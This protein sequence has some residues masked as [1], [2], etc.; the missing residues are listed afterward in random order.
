MALRPPRAASPVTWMFTCID[1]P[2]DKVNCAEAG[3]AVA[4]TASPTS[5]TAAHSRRVPIA[6]SPNSRAAERARR[7]NE[8]T[9]CVLCRVAVANVRPVSS[10]TDTLL[11]L[12]RTRRTVHLRAGGWRAIRGLSTHRGQTLVQDVILAIRVLIMDSRTAASARSTDR[13]CYSGGVTLSGKAA[14]SD[15]NRAHGTRGGWAPLLLELRRRECELGRT[16]TIVCVLPSHD[17]TGFMATDSA[18]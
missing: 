8:T 12:T 17:V 16:R 9:S 5:R 14:E 15:A 4:V 1:G 11:T 18:L 13:K 10:F 7:H 3:V 6:S 2:S